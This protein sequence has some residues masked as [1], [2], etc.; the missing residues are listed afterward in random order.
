MFS[1]EPPHRGDSNKNTQYTIFNIKKK[2]T[3]N[4]PDSAVMGFLQETQHRGK[5]A[6]SVRAT[7]VLLYIFFKQSDQPIQ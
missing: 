6:F 5:Q 1:L 7:I 3:L 4:Y 2:I